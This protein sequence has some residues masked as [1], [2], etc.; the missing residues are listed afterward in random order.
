M[1]RLGGLKVQLAQSNCVGK[2]KGKGRAE[3]LV[4]TK[5]DLGIEGTKGDKPIREHWIG[6]QVKLRAQLLLEVGLYIR[7]F[8]S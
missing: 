3:T 6:N 8:Q 5:D 1:L 7:G 4:L 2:F